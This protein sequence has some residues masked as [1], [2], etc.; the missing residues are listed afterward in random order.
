M[1]NMSRYYLKFL[2]IKHMNIT[3]AL[4]K[5]NDNTKNFDGPLYLYEFIL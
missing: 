2:F 3:G 1:T 5:P 4:V